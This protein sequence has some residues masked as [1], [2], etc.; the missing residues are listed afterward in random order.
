MSGTLTL[1]GSG[2]NLVRLPFLPGTSNNQNPM[3]AIEF[4]EG[5]SVGSSSNCHARILYDGGT[6]HGGDGSI[7]FNGYVGSNANTDIAWFSRDGN[8]YAQSSYRAPI[9]Y[10]KDNTNYYVNPAGNSVF[11]GVAINGA[12]LTSGYSLQTNGSFHMNNQDINYVN[13]LHFYDNLR[14]VGMDNDQY[15][16]Y[17]WGDTGSGG[18]IFYDG[19]DTRHGYIYGD[20]SGRFGL[21]DNDGSWAVKLGTGTEA[22]QLHC[23]GD[24]EFEVTETYTKSLTSSRAPIFYDSN[25]TNYYLDPNATHDTALRIRGGALHGPNV[26]WGDYLLVGGDGRQNYTNN[27]TTA[28]VCTTNGNLHLDAASGH[29]LY[30]NYYDGSNV[31]FGD[32]GNINVAQVASDGTFRSPVFYDYND[33]GYYL[34][35]AGDST[36]NGLFVDSKI[37][38]KD[39]ASQDDQRGIY[40]DGGSSTSYAIY[41][42]A[43]SWTNP[44]PDLVIGFHTGIKIGGHKSYNGTRFYNREPNGSEALVME[45]ANNNDNVRVVNTFTASGDSRAPIFYDSDNTGYYLNPASTSYVNQI[46]SAGFVKVNEWLRLNSTGNAG[47]Y[48]HNSSG[49]GYNW[50]IFPKDQN[51]MYF[52]TGNSSG[53]IAGTVND[54]TVRGYIH[55]TTSTEIGFLNSS[56]NW[57]LRCDN[58]GNIYSTTSSRAPIFYDSN[59]TNYYTNPADTSY[60]KYLGRR[61]HNTGCLV[62]SYNNVGGNSYKSNPIYA[63]GSSYLP[64]N[65]TLSNFYGIG[66]SHSNASFTPSHVSGWGMYVASD[67]DA[68]VYLDAE[69]GKVIGTGGFYGAS[70][71][72]YSNSGYYLDPA[73]SSTSLNVAGAIVAAGNVTAYSDIKFKED[74]KVIPDAV[75]KVKA[76][77]GVTYT[78]N[79]LKDCEER[80]TGVIA[81]EVEQVLPEAVREGF[82]GKTVAYGN[83]VG[84]L[85]EAIKEQQGMINRQQDDINNLK[86][87]IKD[88]QK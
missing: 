70:F 6:T 54:N 30:L 51:D 87:Q 28:S 7:V 46:E 68:R 71:S 47:I 59:D 82:N 35:P 88:L 56:R 74:I 4:W 79:D 33:T 34:N 26:T 1:T 78:R 23:N 53:G 39:S 24:L 67:G 22:M 10:D 76:I 75:E 8:A 66:Y 32:G 18:I 27:T 77:R 83:M 44:Y 55:W 19:D 60:V 41:R 21:L 52:R 14:F 62:G 17:K 63:I 3:H 37:Y 86:Q 50:H 20:G 9:F 73:S 45:V 64:N 43:G 36:I 2:E 81:Q 48:W 13:Q 84:L 49:A 12:T 38:F 57:S 16:K 58:S 61:D 29:N 5:T 80:H 65:D 15:L 40:F 85:I 25:D 69:V 31:Y 72:D 11:N 42:E